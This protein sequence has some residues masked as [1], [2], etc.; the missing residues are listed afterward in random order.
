MQVQ[1]Q[2]FSGREVQILKLAGLA[3][4]VQNAGTGGSVTTQ[5]AVKDILDLVAEIYI[6]VVRGDILVENITVTFMEGWVPLNEK[7]LAL[8][9]SNTDMGLQLFFIDVGGLVV[10]TVA[11]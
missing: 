8:P 11:L 2:R 7:Y 1:Q 4:D 9:E 6:G 3:I 10:S 5:Q